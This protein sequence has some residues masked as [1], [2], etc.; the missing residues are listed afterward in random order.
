[1]STRARIKYIVSGS[2][3]AILGLLLLTP[4]LGIIHASTPAVD[5]GNDSQELGA[6]V[7]G[8]ISVANPKLS[9]PRKQIL[10][11]TF[12]RVTT[13]IFDKPEDRREFA[14]V[15]LAE[16]SYNPSIQDSSAGAVGL[17]Q[18]L[19]QYAKDFGKLCHIS[20]FTTED[21]KADTELNLT[22]G[23]C[24]FRSLIEEYKGNS[25]L[26]HAGYLAGS[27][28]RSIKQMKALYDVEDPMVAR[29]LAKFYYIKEAVRTNTLQK[30]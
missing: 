17:S 13:D 20:D 21:L 18:L 23:A 15:I 6:L 30:L 14:F 28:S 9:T 29:Y 7:V 25:A 19:P 8:L 10:A 12:V 11:R 4:P 1:M 26:A 16:S 22:V 27:A 24:L 2:I 5:K 3:I